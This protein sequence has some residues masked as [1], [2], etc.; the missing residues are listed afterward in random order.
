MSKNQI[1]YP[2]D[3]KI[4]YKDDIEYRKIFRILF[5]MTCNIISVTD[6]NQ[7]DIDE[8]T[9]DEWN[10]DSE[11][12]TRFM[13]LIYDSTRVNPIFQDL[14]KKSAGLML[15]E[16]YEIGLAILFSYDYL[17]LFHLVLCDYF[18][19]VDVT[20]SEPIPFDEQLHSIIELRKKL[21]R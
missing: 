14:Y 12:T 7:E 18:K 9:L 2:T 19:Y 16:D 8:I 21:T 10:Y 13:D 5:Q 11:S 15:S 4:S 1:F 20:V 6:D 17:V 3:M